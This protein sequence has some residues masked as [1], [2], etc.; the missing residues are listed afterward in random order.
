MA[1]FTSTVVS[2][3]LAL[4]SG[5]KGLISVTQDGAV[6]VLAV[7]S[8]HVATSA[9][10]PRAESAFVTMAVFIALSSIFT[11]IFFVLMGRFRL[12]SLIRY[13]PFPVIGGFLAAVGWILFEGAFSLLVD[14]SF[15]F[16]TLGDLLEE[17]VLIRWL[18]AMVFG[19]A[20]FIITRLK[21]HY[22]II[23]AILIGGIVLFF[24]VVLALGESVSTVEAGGWMLGPFEH[25]SAWRPLFLEDFSLV[26]WDLILHEFGHI[27]TIAL[28][29]SIALLLNISG[30]EVQSDDDIE[31][32][33]ELQTTGLA[34]IG[35]GIF[36]GFVGFHT[37]SISLLGWRM[38]G[39]GRLLGV[40][41][42]LICLVALIF[43]FS[44]YP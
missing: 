36:G 1:L 37:L 23:P 25:D 40:I 32:K 44:I 17:D 30:L 3:V 18:P 8:G 31:V 42:G 2:I 20:M 29:S 38:Q 41:F 28:V 33:G 6:V 5:F 34:N 10:D 7:V 22:L 43:G 39:K 24:V 15:S 11:G 4:T 35:M 9:V 16:S 12:G 21:S 19:V 14:Y 13:I 27:P 26:D